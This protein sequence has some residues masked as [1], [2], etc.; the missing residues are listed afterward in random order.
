MRGKASAGAYREVALIYYAIA[1]GRKWNEKSN[2]KLAEALIDD[3]A[4]EF[5]QRRKALKK[6][7]GYGRT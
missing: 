3:F 4:D 5:D 6:E 7:V 1:Y 2:R